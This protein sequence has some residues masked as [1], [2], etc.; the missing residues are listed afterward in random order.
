MSLE[1]PF[2]HLLDSGTSL[3]ST[4]STGGSIVGLVGFVGFIWLV[5]LVRFVRF[6]WL[7][8]FVW[9]V[10]LLPHLGLCL[11]AAHGH[12]GVEGGHHLVTNSGARAAEV[13][14]LVGLQVEPREVL[15]VL[16]HLPGLAGLTRLAGL[17]RLVGLIWLVAAATSTSA[18]IW[19]I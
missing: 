18:S 12:A 10:W 8:G 1:E 7:V 4:I 11:V 16:Q 17:A 19:L 15:D 14:H 6:V 3:V 13:G 9:L 2:L 5:G